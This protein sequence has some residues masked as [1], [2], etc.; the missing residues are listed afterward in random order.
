[1]KKHLLLLLLLTGILSGIHAQTLDE[2][3]KEK[4]KMMPKNLLTVDAGIGIAYGID[5]REYT[6]VLFD[7]PIGINFQRRFG[8]FAI[9][10]GAKFQHLTGWEQ[11][12]IFLETLPVQHTLGKFFGRGEFLF[13]ELSKGY[14][15]IYIEGGTFRVINGPGETFSGA[16]FGN[17]GGIYLIP[18]TPALQLVLQYN[19]EVDHYKTFI[20]GE[21]VNNIFITN[22]LIAGLRINLP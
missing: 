13:S 1:M 16:F 18:L 14:L 19:L 20:S 21:S 15:G 9:G 3:M 17:I 7:F 12:P 8:R 2:Q 11:D 6:S 5:S 10:G 4:F 22:Q